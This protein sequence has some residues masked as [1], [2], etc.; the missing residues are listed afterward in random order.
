[1][2]LIDSHLH[3]DTFQETG[4]VASVIERARMGGVRRMIAIGGS[5]AANDLA[6]SLASTYPGCVYAVVGYDR[7]MAGLVSGSEHAAVW[8]DRPGVVGIGETGLDY[9]HDRNTAAAQQSLFAAMMELAADHGLPLVIHSREAV[10]DTL[11]MLERHRARWNGE[12]A[13]I[14]VLHCFTGDADFAARLLELGL[15]ISFSGIVTF[16]NAGPLREVA[17]AIPEDRILVET[18]APFLAP[19]PYRGKRN[20]PAWVAQVATVLAEI[21]GTTPAELAGTTS[22]NAARLFGLDEETP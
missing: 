12:A 5:D 15:H 2:E 11:R 10:A 6:V 20:E 18:D 21:R 1:M 22:R 14:G 8:V 16:R 7:A 9:H 17:A 3:F 19:A 13:R 4:E